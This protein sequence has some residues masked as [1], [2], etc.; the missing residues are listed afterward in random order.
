LRL[1]IVICLCALFSCDYIKP[2]EVEQEETVKT[3]LARVNDNF[4]Y[5][6]DLGSLLKEASNHDDSVSIIN[7]FVNSWIRQQLM[8]KKAEEI[9]DMNMSEIERKVDDYRYALISFEFKKRFITENLNIDVSAAEISEYYQ[10]NLDNFLLNQ[11][12]IRCR[13]IQVPIGAPKI[14]KVSSLIKSEKPKDIKDLSSFCF[15][16]A[17]NYNLEDSLWLNF[18]DIVLNTPLKNIPNKIQFLKSNRF[19]ET[20]D[21][22]FKY[23]LYIKEY[24]IQDQLSPL[25]FVKDQ[26][27]N[28]IINKRK[29]ALSKELEDRIYK[30]AIEQNSFEIY[31]D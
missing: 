16:F 5:Y 21:S 13:Y 12:I 30:E 19:V 9:I 29:V 10:D 18:D 28:I 11:N 2:K 24:K 6:E 8:L 17:S 15:Q 1:Y 26:V 4:L 25:E 31:Q 23:F 27:E 3:A 22:S 7:R 14:R 20:Q